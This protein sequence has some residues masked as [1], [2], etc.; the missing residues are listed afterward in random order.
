MV[1]IDF[2]PQGHVI[3]FEHANFRG[4]HRH[5]FTNEPDLY[6]V[7]VPNEPHFNDITSSIVVLEGTWVFYEHSNYTGS[8]WVLGKGV[9]PNVT[10]VGITNDMISSL[11]VSCG[12]EIIL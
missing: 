9:Y 6:Y 11:S 4:R 10:R 8:S 1:N 2:Q 12:N 5:I 3:L 7:D